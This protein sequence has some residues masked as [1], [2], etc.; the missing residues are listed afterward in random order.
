MQTSM[1]LMCTCALQRGPCWRLVAANC[2]EATLDVA[3]WLSSLA[4]RLL[5]FQCRRVPVNG[6]DQCGA[7]H[8]SCGYKCCG[9][10]HLAAHLSLQELQINVKALAEGLRALVERGMSKPAGQSRSAQ[11]F[12]KYSKAVTPPPLGMF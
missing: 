2:S 7:V 1:L 5:A 4:A 12:S 8:G 3:S 6:A 10:A 9:A 11:G